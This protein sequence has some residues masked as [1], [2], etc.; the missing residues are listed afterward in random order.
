MPYSRPSAVVALSKTPARTAEF[1]PNCRAAAVLSKV[2]RHLA[3]EHGRTSA[4]D[5]LS[6]FIQA[7]KDRGGGSRCF[8]RRAPTAEGVGGASR[9]SR[10][11]QVLCAD[12]ALVLAAFVVVG[13]A[14]W[15]LDALLRG[16]L[17]IRFLLD[18]AGTTRARRR[19]VRVLFANDRSARS[20]E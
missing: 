17:S 15:F 12:A 4:N 1:P 2:H 9:L 19:H 6:G 16:E 14:V 20:K 18:F 8:Y 3:G 7:A 5:D 10:F 11:L 13:D